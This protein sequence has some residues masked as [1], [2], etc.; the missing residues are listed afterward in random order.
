MLENLNLKTA[1]VTVADLIKYRAKIRFDLACQREYSSA[2]KG[3]RNNRVSDLVDSMIRGW[4]I[5][6]IQ[7]ILTGGDTVESCEFIWLLDGNQRITTILKIFDGESQYYPI[8]SMDEEVVYSPNPVNWSNMTA[9]QK[10]PILDYTLFL[11]IHEGLSER[12][13]AEYFK[14]LNRGGVMQTLGQASRGL[15]SAKMANLL[16]VW[17]DDLKAV[18]QLEKIGKSW[19]DSLGLQTVALMLGSVEL[20]SETVVN[21]VI[22]SPADKLETIQNDL[23][24][25][26]KAFF[27]SVAIYDVDEDIK[28]SKRYLKKS[29]LSVILSSLVKI[30]G[31]TIKAGDSEAEKTTKL[32][33]VVDTGIN[34]LQAFFNQTPKT[35]QRMD[36]DAAT[37]TS[38]DSK[39]SI[40]TRQTTMLDI[41]VKIPP[42]KQ[43][44]KPESKKAEKPAPKKNL[45]TEQKTLPAEV[46]KGKLD[47]VMTAMNQKN[48]AGAVTTRS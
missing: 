22:H 42:K 28:V 3:N 13:Q 31:K 39:E 46:G 32:N 18:P 1:V 48:K 29:H 2:W 16:N 20:S 8:D 6:P 4:F 24:T 44:S 12:E 45:P 30:Y 15:W 43:E 11:V 25:V 33:H 19:I 35:T 10:K 37:K 27:E 38:T 17:H 7:V 9:E 40:L 23:K 14:R 41:L 21:S 36:Y 5:Q 34:A 26:S 47:N